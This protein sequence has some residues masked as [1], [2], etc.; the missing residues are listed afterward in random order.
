MRRYEIA[1]LNA[2]IWAMAICCL[3]MFFVTLDMFLM[4][5]LSK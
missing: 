2:C 4:E 3:V 1:L 5:V